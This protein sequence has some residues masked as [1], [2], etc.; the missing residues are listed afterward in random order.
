V[1]PRSALVGER[2]GGV[3][4]VEANRL[5]RQ[6]EIEQFNPLPGDED[7]GWLQ[8]PMSNV[9]LVR[10]IQGIENLAGVF[11]GLLKRQGALE[12]NTSTYSITR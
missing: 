1:C 9:L 4:L 3:I 10:R 8:V 2:P 6:A 7:V 5:L 11:E 12:R